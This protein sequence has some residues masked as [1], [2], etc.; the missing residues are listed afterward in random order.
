[1]KGGNGL[2][3]SQAKVT[4]HASGVKAQVIQRLLQNGNAVSPGTIF[5]R[6]IIP[7]KQAAR[8]AARRTAAAVGRGGSRCTAGELIQKRLGGVARNAV[9][10]EVVVALELFHSLLGGGAIL[11][12]RAPGTISQLIQRLLETQ[13]RA[14]I[15]QIAQGAVR[16]GQRRHGKCAKQ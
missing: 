11:S 10:L 6:G 7:G 1:M 5:Q 13:H 8:C 15:V 4:I 9:H 14:A 12:I 16:F 2:L 3:R